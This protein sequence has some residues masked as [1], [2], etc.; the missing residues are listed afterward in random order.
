MAARN[1][2]LLRLLYG[3]GMRRGEACALDIE[4]I[5]LET[6]SMMVQGKGKNEKAP[7]RI[8]AGVIEAMQQWLEHHP[9]GTGA[10]FTNFD[11]SGK[12]PARLSGAGLWAVVQRIGK[13]VAKLPHDVPGE[14]YAPI[15]VRV[16][17]IRHQAITDA[18]TAT[19]G[20]VARVSK[21]SRHSDLRTVLIYW[22][23]CQDAAGDVAEIVSSNLD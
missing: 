13:D 20:D 21:F 18:L 14:T 8:P 2:C 6:A 19:N 4:D 17:G 10:L 22:D 12:G 7:M 16:H 5:S 11:T 3:T 15:K 9:T 1:N 23:Q